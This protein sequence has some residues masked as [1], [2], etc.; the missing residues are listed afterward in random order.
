MAIHDDFLGRTTHI[1]RNASI[2]RM[3]AR[4]HER[5]LRGCIHTVYKYVANS[6][7]FLNLST[8]PAIN[9][10]LII[11]TDVGSKGSPIPYRGRHGNIGVFTLYA[12]GGPKPSLGPLAS[13]PSAAYFCI[14]R[15]FRQRIRSSY[16]MPSLTPHARCGSTCA[17]ENCA[18]VHEYF[19]RMESVVWSILLLLVGM[20]LANNNSIVMRQWYQVV[21]FADVSLH[22]EI[23]TQ[24]F[25][26]FSFSFFRKAIICIAS[27]PRFQETLSSPHFLLARV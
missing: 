9:S 25:L 6:F 20:V 21:S 10:S 24:H 16:L 5:H 23:R 1:S 19:S 13:R 11:C 3:N 4:H 15:L 2:R 14:S 8:K 27:T 26:S 12:P 7:E 22:G 17:S 18:L